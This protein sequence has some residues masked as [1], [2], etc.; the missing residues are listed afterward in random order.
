MGIGTITQYQISYE[1]YGIKVL[2]IFPQSVVYNH[3]KKKYDWYDTVYYI[4]YNNKVYFV[5]NYQMNTLINKRKLI[6][7][8]VIKISLAIKLMLDKKYEGE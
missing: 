2:N 4:K 7:Q 6:C 3:V 8:E 5:Q 1:A